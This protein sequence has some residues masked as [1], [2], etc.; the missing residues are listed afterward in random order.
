MG[1]LKKPKRGGQS[2]TEAING[3]VMAL[4]SP[5][6]SAAQGSKASF[7]DHLL[8]PRP[9]SCASLLSDQSLVTTPC[10][11]EDCLPAT[12]MKKGNASAF[13]ENLWPTVD[14]DESDEPMSCPK[15]RRGSR[16][17]DPK[18]RFRSR[19]RKFGRF[20]RSVNKK[21][22]MPSDQR[23]LDRNDTQHIIH[24]D[25][26][27][28]RLHLAPLTNPRK[29]LDVGT[30]TG[31]WAK[32]YSARNPFTDVLGID[33]NPIPHSN[34][35]G[36]CFFEQYDA[37]S[38]WRFPYKFDFIHARSLGEFKN[39]DKRK[40]FENI[41]E[42]LEPGGWVEFR[43]WIVH[44]QSPDNSLWGTSIEL[45]NKLLD[46]G[47]RS[48]PPITKYSVPL[49][50]WPPGKRCKRVGALMNSNAREAIESLS[51]SIFMD[52]LGWSAEELSQ[53][54]DTV[55]KD[56]GDTNIHCFISLM[57]VYCQKPHED[58]T[59]DAPPG[60]ALSHSL[61]TLRTHAG[62]PR[63]SMQGRQS[64]TLVQ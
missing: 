25:L 32:E 37:R 28:G 24:L 18:H 50:E 12:D 4:S 17:E 41:Y 5:K 1:T 55:Y 44:V 64:S 57:I 59:G 58:I 47:A 10:F 38:K 16:G 49:N 26:L 3:Q 51:P 62:T 56:L 23:E 61:S 42:N 34:T 15:S 63:G 52:V 40:L 60:T 2:H 31:I 39:E 29:V 53:L 20:G 54:L 46:K 22:F 19:V 48:R 35:T 45:W 11:Q 30:G 14:S 43:E 7:S 27:D 6:L 33:I 36:N 21:Y 13:Q 9:A 8:R